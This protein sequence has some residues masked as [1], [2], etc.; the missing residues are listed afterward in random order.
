MK[1][2]KAPLWT[3]SDNDTDA[4]LQCTSVK[5][6]II[7]TSIGAKLGTVAIYIG[8]GIGIGSV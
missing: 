4:K 7:S 2:T 5:H 3:Y 1:C 8:I 6:H